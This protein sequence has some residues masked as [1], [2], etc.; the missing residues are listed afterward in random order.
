MTI[1]T[2]TLNPVA[3][4]QVLEEFPTLNY[5]S[6][7]SLASGYGGAGKI[8][9][10]YIQFVVPIYTGNVKSTKI[11]LYVPIAGIYPATI[12]VHVMTS[13]YDDLWIEGTSDG[14]VDAVGCNW[15]DYAK[16]AN[17]PTPGGDFDTEP[18]GIIVF[19]VGDPIGW[20][21]I[22]IPIDNFTFQPGRTF[23]IVLVPT[24]TTTVKSLL[25][26]SREA[27]NKP[28]LIVE[29]EIDGFDAPT[30]TAESISS[31]QIDISWNESELDD[32]NFTHYLLEQSDTGVGGWTT[33]ATITDKETILHEHTGL[34]LQGDVNDYDEDSDTYPNGRTKYYRLSV[35][36]D[37]FGASGY[38]T[39]DA[40]TIPAIRPVSLS[41]ESKS[42]YWDENFIDDNIIY[43]PYGVLV[44]PSWY[45]ND[46]TTVETYI[47]KLT[48]EAYFRQA[49]SWPGSPSETVDFGL[50]DFGVGGII[51]GDVGYKP[52]K[53]KGKI[54]D[55]GGLYRKATTDKSTE[56]FDVTWPAPCPV[57]IP[58]GAFSDPPPALSGRP[59]SA[60]SL[61]PINLSLAGQQDGEDIYNEDFLGTTPQDAGRWSAI[62]AWVYG[63]GVGSAP[64]IT[65]NGTGATLFWNLIKVLKEEG[66]VDNDYNKFFSKYT[67]GYKVRYIFRFSNNWDLNTAGTD[68]VIGTDSWIDGTGIVQAGYQVAL[69]STDT[70]LRL[71]RYSNF[72]AGSKTVLA[73]WD[74]SIDAP[75]RNPNKEQF[76]L[77]DIYT[78]PLFDSGNEGDGVLIVYNIDSTLV[79]VKNIDYAT[80]THMFYYE[81]ITKAP[82]D[83]PHYTGKTWFYINTTVSQSNVTL[84]VYEAYIKGRV[85]GQGYGAK[86]LTLDETLDLVNSSIPT[87]LIS[88]SPDQSSQLCFIEGRIKNQNGA[89]SRTGEVDDYQGDIFN[90]ADPVAVLVVSPIGYNGSSL[91]ANGTLSADPEG[92]DLIYEWDWDD[93]SSLEQT[94][95]GL[96]SHIYSSTGTF[97]IK[98]RVQDE[99]G[100]WSTWVE[101]VV[102]IVDSTQIFVPVTFICP[103]PFTNIVPVRSPGDSGTPMPGKESTYYQHNKTGGRQF[104]ISG[105]TVECSNLADSILIA[106]AK[107][108]IDLLDSYNSTGQLVEMTLP[109]YGV[110]NGIITGF[111]PEI[112]DKNPR[113]WTWKLILKEFDESQLG[114]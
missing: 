107:T 109:V 4:S 87:F 90:N 98:L 9:N 49:S 28:E 69:N 35:V 14:A 96:N 85:N 72:G 48:V 78:S 40:T 111:V 70:N 20:Y 110:V 58:S 11:R 75:I 21:E 81:D 18:I 7:V 59:F 61:I 15:N 24:D 89:Q 50:E 33:L 80:H 105:M 1:E 86:N 43:K 74:L 82:T 84:E 29:I 13:P 32:D 5:G 67:G 76:V 63:V 57:A 104:S 114:A 46:D 68:F 36:S 37:V 100:N 92:G 17:W 91:S 53:I 2:M 10:S 19:Q 25:F 38:G 97:T 62:S 55:T 23:S 41:F 60:G 12:A 52:Y 56:Q 94:S 65:K 42:K 30:L 79:G 34:V 8:R 66:A 103:E 39:A 95:D 88:C 45:D 102:I 113:L 27:T 64:V 3:D 101:S 108:E 83:Q 71:Q 77:I 16:L 106:N 47:D 26:S 31:T 54:Y 99:A 44:V 22:D 73:T 51:E 112:N 6:R 93:G